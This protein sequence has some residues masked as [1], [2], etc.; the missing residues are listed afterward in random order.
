MSRHDLA[1]NV[2]L[3]RFFN[4]DAA[5]D[6]A[7]GLL[8]RRRHE[9]KGRGILD[10]VDWLSPSTLAEMLGLTY[11]VIPRIDLDREDGRVAL[12]LLDLSKR[13]V[14]VSEEIGLEAAR[15]TGAHELGH[16]LYH[17][18]RVRQHWERELDPAERDPQEREADQFAARFLMPESL[19]IRRLRENFSEPPIRIDEKWLYFLLGDQIDLD[20]Q[21][22]DLEY[23]LARSSRNSS[24]QQIIPL[25]QQFKVSKKAMAIRLQEI[26]A[27]SYPVT[28]YRTDL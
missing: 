22:L 27:L 4:V 14:L 6:Y 2:E 23:A 1:T 25:H 10:P 26:R 5:V 20:P 11:E 12:G 7:H 9:F 24:Y 3:P 19:L 15:Y 17:Q 28:S 8:R 13:S 16:A 18:G 21:K